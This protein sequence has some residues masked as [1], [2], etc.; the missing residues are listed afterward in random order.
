MSETRL[1]TITTAENSRNRPWSKGKILG[2]DRLHREQAQ[3][4]VGEH[5]LD[6]D[7]TP[8]DRTRMRAAQS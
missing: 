5:V 7:P 4:G 3:S 6:R 1:A 8:E 2:A